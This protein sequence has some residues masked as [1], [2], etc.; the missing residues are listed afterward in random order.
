MT[1]IHL[2]W[3]KLSYIAKKSS[4][5]RYLQLGKLNYS[6]VFLSWTDQSW[7]FR[8]WFWWIHFCMKWVKEL[9]V[10]GFAD[11]FELMKYWIKPNYFNIS[12]QPNWQEVISLQNI[13]ISNSSLI[14]LQYCFHWLLIIC[15][16]L[17]ILVIDWDVNADIHISTKD[18]C[19]SSYI[20]FHFISYVN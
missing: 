15:N 4:C 20:S 18:D 7:L 1:F 3:G 13:Y 14:T 6:A 12:L 10:V 19:I 11:P 5:N 17:W 16:C 2:R 9:L 8:D